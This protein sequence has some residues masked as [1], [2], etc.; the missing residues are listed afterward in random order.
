LRS[1]YLI[2]IE[3]RSSYT[4]L[5]QKQ[6]LIEKQTPLENGRFAISDNGI[7]LPSFL[8]DINHQQELGA[9]FNGV[10]VLISA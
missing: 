3:D 4:L 7:K 10:N 5:Y 8:Q 6:C 1:Q 2:D 9:F